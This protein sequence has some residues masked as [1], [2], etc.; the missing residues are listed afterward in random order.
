MRIPPPLAVDEQDSHVLRG[1]IS[2]G[3][4]TA[5]RRA[6]IVLLA[7]EGLGPSAIAGELRCSKQT[8]ITWRERYRSG[9]L[10]ALRDA[11]RSGRPATVDADA[12]VRRT[13]ECPE[14]SS[15]RWSTR[16]LA[17]ELGIS[18]VAVANVWRAW[19]IAPAAGGRVRLA[20][21]PALES[22]LSAVAGLYLDP[23][24]RILAVLV[25]TDE[26]TGPEARALPVECRSVPGS[27]LTEIDTGQAGEGDPTAPTRFLNGLAGV[28]SSHRL[29]LLVEGA[30][31]ELRS[32][33]EPPDGAVIHRV[34][35]GVAWG[36]VAQVACLVASASSAGAAS[37]VALGDAVA[38]HPAGAAFS[39][40]S[41]CCN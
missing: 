4:P 40:I 31:E 16:T 41:P 38:G 36:R 37:V 21:E 27:L 11:P 14:L 10:A 2:Q 26:G 3:A 22:P 12:L 24:L 9:G 18:N 7:A 13:L 20:T 1:W 15:T 5:V 33:V 29:G 6:R 19:G 35:R 23:R 8:V 17:A 30:A 25:G 32:C 28:G 34:A 39:W